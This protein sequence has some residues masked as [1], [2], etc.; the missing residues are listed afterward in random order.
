MESIPARQVVH[1]EADEYDSKSYL[2]SL[3]ELIEAIHQKGVAHGDLRSPTNALIDANGNAALVDF[4]ASL[5]ES[6]WNIAS[7]YFFNKMKMVDFSAITKLK[8]RI[9]PELLDDTDFEADTVAG[10]KGMLFRRAGQ[11]IRIASR[12]LF[13]S[14]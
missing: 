5:N 2:K 12:K 1:V 3:R 13:S 9:A 8:K 10:K 14:K 4:V 11:F 7:N 6:N